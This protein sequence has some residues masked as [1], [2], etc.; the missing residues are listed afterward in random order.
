MSLPPWPLAR[1]WR[2]PPR[3]LVWHRRGRRLP[4]A[5]GRRRRC[6]LGASVRSDLATG[7]P[8]GRWLAHLQACSRWERSRSC[9]CRAPTE[10]GGG[11]LVERGPLEACELPLVLVA[12]A[13]SEA[14]QHLVLGGRGG[15]LGVALGDLC[16][17]LAKLLY[18]GSSLGLDAFEERLAREQFGGI[19][20]VGVAGVGAVF[21]VGL[22]Q[23]SFGGAQI[24]LCVGAQGDRPR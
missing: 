18:V 16:F 1:R 3:A 21:D 2:S 10:A 24:C 9:S 22:L 7:A 19:Q 12:V 14:A 17:A 20:R 8:A 11:D 13:L 6:L 4:R 15:E 23:M 5:P